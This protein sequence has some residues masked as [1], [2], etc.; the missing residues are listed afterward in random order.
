MLGLKHLTLI[1]I[2]VENFSKVYL[3]RRD[4]L[5]DLQRLLG[6]VVPVVAVGGLETKV[7][8]KLAV[9]NLFKRVV[10][11][12]AVDHGDNLAVER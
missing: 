4:L 11:L 10:K 7:E 2:S 9:F 3:G 6:F 8:L 1:C 5:D 12:A